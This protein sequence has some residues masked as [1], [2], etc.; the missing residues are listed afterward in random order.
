MDLYK[1]Y[2]LCTIYMYSDVLD[3]LHHDPGFEYKMPLSM[4]IPITLETVRNWLL[5]GAGQ[6]PLVQVCNCAS[7]QV[8][9]GEQVPS[10]IT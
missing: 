10:G 4:Y 7:L 5:D 1:L 6:L 9:I 2:E 8:D 3:T